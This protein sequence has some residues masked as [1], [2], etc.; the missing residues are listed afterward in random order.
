MD[1]NINSTQ[2]LNNGVEIPLLGLGT[3]DLRGRDAYKAVLW[4]LDLGYRLIDTASFYRNEK[5]V[6]EA[7]KDTNIPREE[8]FLTTK[9]WNNEQGYNNTLNAFE[10]SL[11]RLKVD[12]VD[13]YLIHWPIS[14]LR[15]KTW[16]ALEKIYE[17]GKTRAMGVSNFTIRHLKELFECSET[18]PTVNQIEF[19]PFLFQRE[20]MDYCKSHKIVVE[21][22][23]PLTRG[24]KLDNRLVRA[25]AQKHEKTP[26]QILIRWDLQHEI[27]E[28]PK[29]GSQQH[30]RENVD[31]F[32][33][34]LNSEEMSQL[35][36]LNEGFRLGN[37]PHF[38]D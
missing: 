8:I 32:D 2:K 29:S 34:T 20:L 25:L 14:G 7:L 36:E 27:I 5:E 16:K 10:K 35:D 33:F 38:I 26:A 6:G 15:N 1:L 4:S 19:S 17:G 23:T 31:V 30:L 21:A 24:R 28:I 18:I 12:Y 3:W 11:E 22:Y 9:V 13:L 37:D